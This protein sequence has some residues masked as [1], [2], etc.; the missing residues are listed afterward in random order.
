[1]STDF[2]PL[3]PIRMTDLFDG[4]LEKAGVH[5]HHSKEVTADQKCLTDGRRFLWVYGNDE[6]LVSTFTTYGGN[7]TERILATICDEFDVDLVSEHD[8]EFW[9]FE[10][11]EEWDAATAAGY[12]T[13]GE[14]DA[15]MAGDLA[16]ARW[17]CGADVA[18]I[19]RSI[20]GTLKYKPHIN[21]TTALRRALESV[22]DHAQCCD[23][24]GQPATGADPL[25]PY[26]WQ[27]RPD[28]I[29][30]HRQCEARWFDSHEP[31]PVSA[32]D[33]VPARPMLPS[34][35]P[36]APPVDYGKNLK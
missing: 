5:E 33:P 36:R 11:Q 14:W 35:E 1:M 24:C 17:P 34:T 2:C 26:D 22:I 27:G 23:H 28:G 30:L 31:A 15:A 8:P 3:T 9:G 29:W 19:A 6:G 18:T 12:W 7:A 32:P 10:T 21:D 4:R 16:I 25:S 13:K 20:L